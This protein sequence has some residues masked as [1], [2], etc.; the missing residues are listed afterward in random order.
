MFKNNEMGQLTSLDLSGPRITNM[1]IKEVGKRAGSKLES[2]SVRD[3]A[4]KPDYLFEIVKL[5]P[6]LTKLSVSA[7]IHSPEDFLTRLS[8]MSR[9][10][11][12]EGSSSI[13]S[14]LKLTNNYS[15][16]RLN[17]EHFGR[18]GR[19]EGFTICVE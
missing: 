9:L 3:V 15:F 14:D 7:D 12:G 16:Y 13:I 4:S 2:L 6:V 5:A 11:R 19:G 1:V 18:R 17:A 10:T 8:A